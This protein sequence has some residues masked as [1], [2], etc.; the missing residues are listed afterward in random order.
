MVRA[1]VEG[2]A[3]PRRFSRA[4]SFLFVNQ[5]EGL[6]ATNP[7]E[8]NTDTPR[9]GK[10]EGESFR[11]PSAEERAYFFFAKA[12][13]VGEEVRGRLSGRREAPKTPWRSRGDCFVT[14]FLATTF[15]AGETSGLTNPIPEPFRR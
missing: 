2:L 4:A 1:N 7:F 5:G 13:G 11:K 9:L 15:L 14:G 10:G 8:G 12:K 3:V 6:V